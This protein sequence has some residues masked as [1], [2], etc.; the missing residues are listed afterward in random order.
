MGWYSVGQFSFA[1]LVGTT[2]IV[3]DGMCSIKEEVMSPGLQVDCFFVR[4]RAASGKYLDRALEF[5][6]AIKARDTVHRYSG[7]EHSGQSPSDPRRI[8]SFAKV[9]PLH[10]WSRSVCR[11]ARHCIIGERT[12]HV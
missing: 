2:Q 3:P 11:A 5:P 7:T 4:L 6:S 12:K 9:F 1:D 10:G 8:K